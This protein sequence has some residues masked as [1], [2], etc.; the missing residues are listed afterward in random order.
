M[1]YGYEYSTMDIGGDGMGGMF[2]AL[3]GMMMVVWI[4]AMALTV[5]YVVAMWRIYSKAGRPG[6]A[7]LVPFY[8]NYVLFDMCL[9][10]GW[11][12]LTCLVPFVNIYFLIKLYLA[13]AHKFGC[14]TAFGIGL[15][16]VSPVFLLILAF[17]DYQY[18]GGPVMIAGRAPV[19]S[20]V[21]ANGSQ[22]DAEAR[23]QEALAKMRAQR[24]ARDSQK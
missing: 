22:M 18:E 5:V 19:P 7:C 4:F 9:G 12:F 10:N 21:A 3:A 8:G 2:G 1:D 15:L 23:R 24:A 17:G 13:M 11:L 20:D 14:S 16:L 6:W